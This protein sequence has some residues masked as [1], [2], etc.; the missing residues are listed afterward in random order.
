MGNRYV[1]LR[2]TFD[3][4]R[5]FRRRR[6]HAFGSAKL[7]RSTP[8]QPFGRDAAGYVFRCPLGR[9][10]PQE[11]RK[12]Q[13][14]EFG[15]R[16]VGDTGKLFAKR[17]WLDAYERACGFTESTQPLLEKSSVGH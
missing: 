11:P 16:E 13:R 1:E 4:W 7:V 17:D 9:P 8:K 15:T 14:G 6:D 12:L 3:Q 5:T 10:E 2:V